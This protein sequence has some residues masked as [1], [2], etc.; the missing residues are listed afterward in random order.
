MVVG[1]CRS[2]GGRGFEWWR[3]VVETYSSVKLELHVY[4]LNSRPVVYICLV[5][6]GGGYCSCDRGKTRSTSSV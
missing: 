4:V 2:V 1:G 6:F 3:W 5:D